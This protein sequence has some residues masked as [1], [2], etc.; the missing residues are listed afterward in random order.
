LPDQPPLD[1]ARG[2][3]QAL[4]RRWLK[5]LADGANAGD[6]LGLLD[7]P[8]FLDG[9]RS[10]NARAYF[11]A[12]EQFEA[13]WRASPYPDRLLPYALSKLGAACHHAPRRPSTAA[14]LARDTL[15]ILDCLPPTYAS[16]DLASFRK[17]LARWTDRHASGDLQLRRLESTGT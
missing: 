13:A 8:D 15:T 16:L 5:H 10:F 17:D 3:R 2:Q 7:I 6:G 9:I 14:K 4:D 11:D 1:Y 12:H